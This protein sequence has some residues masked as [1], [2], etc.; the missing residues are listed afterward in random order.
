MAGPPDAAHDGGGRQFDHLSVFLSYRHADGT[1]FANLLHDALRAHGP[2]LNA[3][4]DQ[5][6]RGHEPFDRAIERALAA[7]QVMMPVLT[8]ED[9]IEWSRETGARS[10]S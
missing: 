9:L 8:P 3:W 4:W 6:I 1:D 7:T 5:H 2:H 10:S